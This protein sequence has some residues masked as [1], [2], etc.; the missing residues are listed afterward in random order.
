MQIYRPG[1]HRV[2]TTDA[3]VRDAMQ[4]LREPIPC[5]DLTGP[6]VGW[7]VETTG[8]DYRKDTL[9]LSQ[10]SNRE[11]NYLVP[12]KELTDTGKGMVR[13]FLTDHD[14]RPQLLVWNGQFEWQMAK[15]NGAEIEDGLTDLML[16]AECI[17]AG[18]DFDHG[19]EA[20]VGKYL[21]KGMPKNMQTAFWGGKFDGYSRHMIDYAVADSEC[22]LD[23]FDVLTQLVISNR[24]QEI[25]Q[26]NLDCCI[27]YARMSHH[28]MGMDADAM[29]KL[30]DEKAAEA[31][32]R[33][34][35]V[36]RAMHDWRKANGLPGYTEGQQV[37]AL[38]PELDPLGGLEPGFDID[39]PTE[40]GRHLVSMGVPLE[41]TDESIEKANKDPNKCTFKTK[42]DELKSH[43]EQFP[44]IA[45]Y[46]SYK[47]IKTESE[48]AAKYLA[49]WSPITKR[50]HPGFNVNFAATGRS[51][52]SR[53]NCQNMPRSGAFRGLIL[54]APGHKLLICDFSQIELRVMASITR[55]PVML[56]AYNST[57]KIL[58]DLH[59]R[60]AA[61]LNNIEPEEVTSEQRSKAKNIIFGVM[62]GMAPKALKNYLFVKYD[63]KLSLDEAEI[64]HARFMDQYVGV[65]SYHEEIEKKIHSGSLRE[66]RSI[67]G[68]RRIITGDDARL[69]L[70]ANA[71]VQSCAATIMK[72]AVINIQPVFNE[73]G[74]DSAKLIN[75]V[76]DE[77]VVEVEESQ[78]DLAL[79][80]LIETME[81]AEQQFIPDV[82][83]KAEGKIASS[84]AEK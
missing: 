70:V 32:E 42:A 54:P 40:L 1:P 68:H 65:R 77:A 46:L 26:L 83:A 58:G 11:M 45:D 48:D 4:H 24:L 12:F 31:A 52:S 43:I 29:A 81:L 14:S 3:E 17:Q 28:G 37:L 41:Q 5:G 60:T 20:N 64:Y 9:C 16:I 35:G 53:P 13:D 10:F 6:A 79:K 74:L 2:C 8:T 66:I 82:P 75:V 72:A 62:Y 15:C 55:D 67:G 30:R 47:L 69:S 76:H 49:A 56:A 38:D 50:L 78:A 61:V 19:L 84:W 63:L 21:K 33:K 36:Y 73:F 18:L 59:R 27:P 71:A 57:D 44:F 51:S 7:D 80:L 23:L 22:E 34:P 39:S 25:V